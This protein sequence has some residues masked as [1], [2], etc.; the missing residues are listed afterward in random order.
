M[1]LED[2][3]R[4]IYSCL[5][6]TAE[7]KR[8]KNKSY[9]QKTPSFTAKTDKFKKLETANSNT[10]QKASSNEKQLQTVI[11]RATSPS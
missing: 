8:K 11:V 5:L 3:H 4:Q 10:L 6:I 2:A 7:R 9:L 1:K